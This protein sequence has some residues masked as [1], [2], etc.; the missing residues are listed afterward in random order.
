MFRV[1][2]LGN[3]ASSVGSSDVGQSDVERKEMER[4]T[5][6][7]KSPEGDKVKLNWVR[8]TAVPQRRTARTT[9][10]MQV[11]PDDA[12]AAC[13]AADEPAQDD[14]AAAS[15]EI[16]DPP[17][18]DERD[19]MM[20]VVRRIQAQ[21]SHAERDAGSDGSRWVDTA[22]EAYQ[23]DPV[24]PAA[25]AAAVA[26]APALA[27]DDTDD[28]AVSEMK[29]PPTAACD[30][31]VSPET[32]RAPASSPADEQCESIGSIEQQVDEI[33]TAVAAMRAGNRNVKESPIPA[34]FDSPPALAAA[35][36]S[37]SASS[38]PQRLQPTAVQSLPTHLA[39]A[40][41]EAIV[42]RAAINGD[43]LPAEVVHRVQPAR[44]TDPH[45]DEI[46]DRL[47]QMQA[48]TRQG[49]AA[50]N[51]DT[52]SEDTKPARSSPPMR[53]APSSSRT[54]S[55]SPP[56]LSSPSAES[57]GPLVQITPGVK[58]S[59]ALY[60]ERMRL[61]ESEAASVRAQLSLKRLAPA[62]TK[63]TF[64]AAEPMRAFQLR[65]VAA[66][67]TNQ[68]ETSDAAA[69]PADERERGAERGGSIGRN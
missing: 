2:K 65:P 58:S 15:A 18:F 59:L 45:D 11:D 68:P 41:A 66:R 10:E 6:E 47:R 30:A 3:A 27:P 52:G 19:E 29:S 38:L 49:G 56:S 53:T 32:I 50:S 63:S 54:T 43:A 51:P 44:G 8:Q 24:D 9:K 69:T 14:T 67:R 21:V 17:N 20:S 33:T 40:E 22:E 57:R 13:A 46:D 1:V 62:P 12:N 5:H 64:A 26:A 7:L 37:A 34:S 42:G 4:L 60:E 36:A 39:Q 25:H 48:E 31:S 61:A 35:G 28:T 16:T 55:A 23:N